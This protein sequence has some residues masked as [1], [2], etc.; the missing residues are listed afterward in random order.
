MSPAIA[1]ASG[2]ARKAQDSA[3]AA[4]CV[5]QASDVMKLNADAA[6][7]R[8]DIEGI[9]CGGQRGAPGATFAVTVCSRAGN[10]HAALAPQL[11]AV[12]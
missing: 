9:H 5:P 2:R 4:A 6:R 1:V 10:R 12:Y 7:L 3:T 8:S 11:T